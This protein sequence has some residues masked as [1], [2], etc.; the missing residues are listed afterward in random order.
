MAAALA[1]VSCEP[2]HLNDNM[3]SPVVYI[4]NSGLT[5]EV[6]YSV[7]GTHT[8]TVHAYCGGIESIDPEV[9][10]EI[11]RSALDTYNIN[12]GE[13]LEVLPESCYT[14]ESS[15]K[16]MS[17]NRV[18][19]DIVFDCG[20]LEELSQSE[21]WT[22]ITGYAVPV[23]LRSLTEGV[24][25]SED[26]GLSA[27]IIVPDLRKMGFTFEQAGVNS[28]DLTDFTDKDGFLTYEYR[29]FTPVDNH[30]DN[31]VS[32][33]FP[34]E[35]P[36]AD[37][38]PLPEGSYT[39]TK[40]AEQFSDGVSEIIY[41]VKID[42][43]AA[44]AFNYSL[45]AKVESE[46]G[47]E[48]LGEGTSVL[49]FTN[50]YTYDQSRITA[51]AD[52]YVTGKGADMTLDGNPGTLWESAYNTSASHIGL[53]L[54]PYTIVYTL[55]EPVMLYDIKIDRRS[56]QNLKYTSDLKAGYYEVSTDGETYTKVVDFDY[57]TSKDVTFIHSLDTPAEVK[58]VK[59]VATESNRKSGNY[60]LASIAEMNFYY[61]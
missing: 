11:N 6:I 34:A 22:D 41:T 37:Y 35:S 55:S 15:P 61:R 59:F 1:A 19:F 53:R 26:S 28:G 60:P 29:L 58:Y 54:M 7:E 17:D 3:Y 49:N 9:V 57:G 21:D 20:K 52:T 13:N 36:D 25:V 56:D 4:V 40:S 43:E 44:S 50:R 51:A 23:V 32:F 42:K 16:K 12:T 27:A 46:G 8:F 2:S 39:V 48:L 24:G 47:F 33:T 38:G 5:Q 30:W 18:S 10:A 31:P 45:V 14:L